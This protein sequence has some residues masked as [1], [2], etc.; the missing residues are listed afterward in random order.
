MREQYVVRSADG[1]VS[2]G[3]PWLFKATG[4][5][6][7]GNFDFMVGTV[8]Y[9]CGPPLHVHRE[10]YDT[11]YV[12]EG[13]LTVQVGEDVVGLGPGDFAAIPPGVPHTFDNVD[14]NQPPVR[15]INLMAPGGFKEFFDERAQMEDGADAAALT[16]VAEQHGITTVGPPLRVSLKLD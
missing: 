3:G 15:A 1:V 9:L 10:Q 13:V 12:L 14:P 7:D 6:T 2:D 16:Q 5:D 8:D 4:D 11:F